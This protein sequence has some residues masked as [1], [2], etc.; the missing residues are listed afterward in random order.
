MGAYGGLEMLH[1]L[2]II[3]KVLASERDSAVEAEESSGP[4]RGVKDSEDWGKHDENMAHFSTLL[5]LEDAKNAEL[6][7]EIVFGEFIVEPVGGDTLIFIEV[8]YDPEKFSPPMMDYRRQNNHVRISLESADVIEDDFHMNMSP[9]SADID[10]QR[11]S[12]RNTWHIYLGRDVTWQLELDLAAC[13]TRMELGGLKIENLNVESGL[14]DTQLRFSEPN[15]IVLEKCRIETG[16][17]SFEAFQLGN[18]V[19]RRFSLENG[20]GS[21]VLDFSG[22]HPFEDLKASIES[23]LGSVEMQLP[24]GLPVI[25]QVETFLGSSDLPG[26]DKLNGSKYR[27]I[28]YQEGVPGLEAAVSIGM[29][30]V[31][32]IWLPEMPLPPEAPMLLKEEKLPSPPEVPKKTRVVD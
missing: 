9:G 16:V 2:F 14:S 32:V 27:S 24:N 1:K 15:R 30:S 29:G 11:K 20:L 10:E 22:K 5:L 3:N 7:A 28:S 25:M 17:G 19:I 4:S 26:F 18:A 6:S 21:S 23:G 12:F 31:N 8:E 13:E